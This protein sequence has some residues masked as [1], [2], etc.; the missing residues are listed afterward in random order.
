MTMAEPSTRRSG[1]G[2][3]QGAAA[4]GRPVRRGQVTGRVVGTDHAAQAVMG[5]FTKHGE[6]A[7]DVAPLAGLVKAHVRSIA[8]ARPAPSARE[9]QR[10]D[11]VGTRNLT[12]YFSESKFQVPGVDERPGARCRRRL[13]GV[14]E[15]C[16]DALRSTARLVS[17]VRHV[18]GVSAPREAGCRGSDQQRA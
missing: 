18:T 6:G 5:F 9:R 8:G 11:L 12:A 10:L 2:K 1:Q 17:L 4:H 14:G 16:Q 13:E 3:H 15:S 7:C